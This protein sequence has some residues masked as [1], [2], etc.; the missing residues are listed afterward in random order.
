MRAYIWFVLAAFLAIGSPVMAQLLLTGVG[1]GGVGAGGGGGYAGPG[2]TS[3]AGAAVAFWATFSCYTAAYSGNVM[4]V[5]DT[6]TGDTT[7]TRI[8]C[9][10][11]TASALVSGS[12]CTF[13]TGHACS[14][15]TNGSTGTCD[16]ACSVRQLY[17]QT[18]GN[19]C[20]SASCDLLWNTGNVAGAPALTLNALSTFPCITSASDSKSLVST[21]S[22]TQNQAFTL[23][24]TSKRISGTADVYGVM[25]DTSTVAG[26]IRFGYANAANK[27]DMY[28]GNSIPAGATASDT[29]FHALGGVFANAT[30][31]VL[32][33]DGSSTNISLGGSGGYSAAPAMLSAGTN[34]TSVVVCEGGIWNTDIGS[35]KNSNYSSNVVARYGTLP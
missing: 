9:S 33:V 27:A 10:G 12:A 26:T 5:V 8:Q 31:S 30:Q 32:Y 6:A 35:T 34:T 14:P 20:T 18:A 25:R 29:H 11:G 24:M 16:S 7:G 23:L 21:N 2:D 13:V 17:D 1:T 22:L 19:N 15:L 3:V 28:N 4:D